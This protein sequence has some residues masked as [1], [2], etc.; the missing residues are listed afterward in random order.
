MTV[1]HKGCT[2]Y[3]GRVVEFD[4]DGLCRNQ[5]KNAN[6]ISR[7][8]ACP[9]REGDALHETSIQLRPSLKGRP[10]SKT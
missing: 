3:D 9:T 6:R 7:A 2:L 5:T 1:K 4:I 8:Q 10:L